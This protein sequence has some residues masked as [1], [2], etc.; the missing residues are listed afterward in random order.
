MDGYSWPSPFPRTEWPVKAPLLPREL[1]H[2]VGT[3]VI[4]WNRCE[5]DHLSIIL[6][7]AGYGPS[8]PLDYRLGKRLFQPLGN[9]Q[10]SIVLSSLLEEGSFDPQLVTATRAYQK[11]FD[12]CLY[13]RNL[14]VHAA[15]FEEEEGP[16]VTS[17]KYQPSIRNR[18]LPD[19]APFWEETIAEITRLHR[20]GFDITNEPIRARKSPWPA[21]P[22]SPRN[23][24][25]ILPARVV[26]RHRP[27][28]TQALDLDVP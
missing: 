19:D 27:E 11:Q 24:A 25:D 21:I 9:R 1:A 8:G 3:I 6:E 23:L 2:A 26:E 7:L 17:S 28:T 16:L 20:Y 12:S 14:I 18:H 4:A 15:Y 10:R 13:N 5:D 22:P